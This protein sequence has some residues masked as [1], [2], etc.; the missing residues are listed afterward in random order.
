MS[1]STGTIGYGCG[2]TF[3]TTGGTYEVLS[4]RDA[5]TRAEIDLTHSASPNKSKEY[6]AGLADT[7]VFDIELIYRRG[8]YATL[9]NGTIGPVETITF[10][11]PNPGGTDESIPIEGFITNLGTEIP[12]EDRMTRTVTVR[13]THRPDVA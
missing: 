2:V 6:G 12:V 5:L 10:T 1:Q 11:I 8:E 9:Y 4:I 3:G 7:R 13:E